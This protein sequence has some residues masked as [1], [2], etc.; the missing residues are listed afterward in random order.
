MLAL[1]DAQSPPQF[2]FVPTPASSGV[3]TKNSQR[4]RKHHRPIRVPPPALPPTL[5]PHSHPEKKNKGITHSRVPRMTSSMEPTA[6]DWGRPG[7]RGR[8]V[9]GGGFR[10]REDWAGREREEK[11]CSR[12]RGRGRDLA[13]GTALDVGRWDASLSARSSGSLHEDE[14]EIYFLLH[15]FILYHTVW[16]WGTKQ[17]GIQL[18]KY[19]FGIQDIS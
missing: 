14:R 6:L 17:H 9:R 11:L 1:P 7:T 13:E 19:L 10:R 16:R 5:S 4:V 18:W 12:G 15:C 2:F 8:R 3:T